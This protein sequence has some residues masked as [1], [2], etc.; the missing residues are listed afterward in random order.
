[1]QVTMKL[2][3]FA[4]H[5]SKKKSTIDARITI[6]MH[7]ESLMELKHCYKFSGTFYGVRLDIRSNVYM[8]RI[9]FLQMLRI[10]NN[11]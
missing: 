3:H 11:V 5:I 4:S 1:M 10:E 8:F 9:K 2:V 6:L 7:T